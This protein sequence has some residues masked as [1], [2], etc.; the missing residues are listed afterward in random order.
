MHVIQA[1]LDP[2]DFNNLETDWNP[3]ADFD[4]GGGGGGGG[5][6]SR[7][8]KT[9]VPTGPLQYNYS[10]LPTDLAALLHVSPSGAL[11]TSQAN[12]HPVKRAVKLAS[13]A[14]PGRFVARH[15]GGSAS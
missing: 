7:G 6:N 14:G 3:L 2:L 11:R 10:Y 4:L 1:D 15:R 13:S 12:D 8:S 5:P 9:A